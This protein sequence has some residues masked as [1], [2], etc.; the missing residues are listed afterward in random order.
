M[1]YEKYGVRLLERIKKVREYSNAGFMLPELA[2]AMVLAGLLLAFAAGSAAGYVKH[3][4]FRRND[5]I[6][7]NLFTAVQLQLTQYEQQGRLSQLAEAVSDGGK[8]EPDEYLLYSAADAIFCDGK[9]IDISGAGSWEGEPGEICYLKAGSVRTEDRGLLEKY[10]ENKSVWC[11]QKQQ[12][13]WAYVYYTERLKGKSD[14][15]LRELERR[16]M[17]PELAFVDKKRLKILFDLLEP[18]AADKESLLAAVCIEFAPDPSVGMVY[19][20]FYH[21]RAEE[22]V[23]EPVSEKS[24]EKVSILDRSADVRRQS[25]TGYCGADRL[26]RVEKIK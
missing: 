19:S 17:E 13:L 11:D 4:A 7:R 3:A 2:A 25:M 26:V 5:E 9:E 16:G 6:A 22:L 1:F 21:H 24:Y 14:E 23:Y 12:K 18:C 20:V 8:G 10:K 15:E